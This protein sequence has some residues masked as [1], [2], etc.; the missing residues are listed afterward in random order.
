MAWT[1]TV[2]GQVVPI[3]NHADTGPGFV[4]KG[5]NFLYEDGHVSWSRFEVNNAQA[6]VD[7]GS[8]NGSWLCFYKVPNVMTN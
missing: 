1:A 6:T 5:A 7:V 8:E 4:P 3:S 2:G